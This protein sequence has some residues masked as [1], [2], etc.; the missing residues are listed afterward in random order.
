MKRL[1]LFCLL[2]LSL[3]LP[4]QSADTIVIGSKN[5][6]E[7]RVLA[8]LFAS[9]IES[10]SDLK[11]E[12]QFNLGATGIC[13][14]ALQQGSVDLYPEYT[15]TGLTALLKE[16]VIQDPEAAYQRVKKAFAEKY[17]LDWLPPLSF[18][19]TYALVMR[20][21]Q[22][23]KLG[24]HK[25]SDL[26]HLP[27]EVRQK[28]QLGF[29][30]EFLARPDGW[31]GLKRLYHLPFHEDQVRGLEHGLAYSALIDKKLDLV[32]AYSTDG[33]IPKYP[34]TLLEDDQHYFPPYQ[35]APLVRE[36]SLRR[37]PEIKTILSQLG[38]M[39]PNAEMQQLNYRVEEEGASL[40]TVVRDFLLAK[41]LAKASELKA[42]SQQQGHSLW[43]FFWNRRVRLG[44]LL[45]E[46]LMLTSLAVGL[47]CLIGVPLGIAVAR[48]QAAARY[49]LGTAG[50]IQTIPSLALLGFLVPFIGTG[51][52]PALIA[53]TLYA[54]LPIVRNTYTGMLEVSPQLKEAARGLGMTE[55]QLLWRVEL[56]LAAT[57]MMAG[58]RTA[59]VIAIGTATLAA[60]IGA[61]GLGD[62]II[63]GLSMK[64]VN[65]I[66]FGVIP[67]A[68]LAL[69]ADFLLAGLE[70][71]VSPGHLQ[72]P[73]A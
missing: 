2:L 69:I 53:L 70:K 65:W 38:G 35:A 33:K 13:F 16:A 40:K 39:I 29:T 47:A 9:L 50:I 73:K 58:I 41:G 71:W 18:N 21:Q 34:L 52:T 44:K 72:R 24:I 27:P 26:T 5:F 64:S 28:L 17:Q 46:H 37:H 63:T 4:V 57:I 68:G 22:A 66:L 61:G 54:L 3:A 59:T 23:Q 10:H 48:Y 45:Q 62:P 20:K 30:H 31:P 19:N 43:D 1:L 55:A 14:E 60:F 42:S 25:I 7:S 67:A 12:R 56:P 6:T 8:E 11:V 32:D 51:F 36:D 49:V 15:G